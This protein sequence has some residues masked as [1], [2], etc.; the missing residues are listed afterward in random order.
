LM[1]LDGCWSVWMDV[2]MNVWVFGRMFGRLDDGC[3]FGRW[4]GWMDALLFRDIFVK[5]RQNWKKM[6]NFRLKNLQNFRK[7]NG[8]FKKMQN[9]RE[10]MQNLYIFWHNLPKM[11]FP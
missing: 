7:Q 6:Q 8:K 1:C 9:Y 10:K 3:L 11:S 4:D 5:K 2:W